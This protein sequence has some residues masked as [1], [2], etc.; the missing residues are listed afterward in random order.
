MT[1]MRELHD[2]P[3]AV[4]VENLAEPSL[5][6]PPHCSP[7]MVPGTTFVK[8]RSGRTAER[9]LQHLF[10][11][12]ELAMVASPASRPDWDSLEVFQLDH[13]IRGR[14][15]GAVRLKIHPRLE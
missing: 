5:K 10:E 2:W 6:L 11:E 9:L 3:A 15:D 4:V 7:A 13:R 1:R 12:I 8:Y 14:W